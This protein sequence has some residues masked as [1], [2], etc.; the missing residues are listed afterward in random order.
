MGDPEIPITLMAELLDKPAAKVE[1]PAVGLV[2]IMGPA[3]VID[4]EAL[5]ACK[6]FA[7]PS[8]F[9]APPISALRAANND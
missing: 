3:A 4:V 9:R 5:R 1:G 8:T 6:K 2:T 7:T